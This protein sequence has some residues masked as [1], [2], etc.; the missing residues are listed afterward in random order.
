[1]NQATRPRSSRVSL[2]AIVALVLLVVVMFFWKGCAVRSAEQRVA[3]VRAE[4]QA[5]METVEQRLRE[6]TDERV[7]ELLQLLGVPLGWAVRT[8]AISDDYDQIEEYAN[9]LVKE[10]RVRRVVFVTPEGSVRVST[11]RKLQGEPAASYFG[12][13]VRQERITLRRD[14][15][16]DYQL[17]VPILGYSGRLGSL[18]VTVAGD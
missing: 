17:M 6:L 2:Y 5:D 10:P 7:E 3:A 11:D 8:E 1:M 14:E 4:M 9:L 16:G 13:L 18:V 12:D 15:A